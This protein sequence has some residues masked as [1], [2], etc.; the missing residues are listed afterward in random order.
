MCQLIAVYC[1]G[2]VIEVEEVEGN[3]LHKVIFHFIQEDDREVLVRTSLHIQSRQ[4]QSLA[5]QRNQEG[6]TNN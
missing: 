6:Q 1:Y 3:Y 4:L 5:Q 2:E